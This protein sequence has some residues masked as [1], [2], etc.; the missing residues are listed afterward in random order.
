MTGSDNII[1]NCNKFVTRSKQTVTLY[2]NT[3]ASLIKR[4]TNY[5]R[6]SRLN[7]RVEEFDNDFFQYDVEEEEEKEEEL[8]YHVV[9][10]ALNQLNLHKLLYVA[11][12]YTGKNLDAQKYRNVPDYDRRSAFRRSVFG[13]APSVSS[14]LNLIEINAER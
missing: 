5:V 7:V 6:S 13:F 14:Q 1:G 8:D 12:W 4:P 11:A 10:D 9:N 2:S 3:M